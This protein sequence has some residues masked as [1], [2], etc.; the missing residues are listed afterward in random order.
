ML[1][2]N[3]SNGLGSF[4]DAL[5]GSAGLFAASGR[6][7]MASINF[8]TAHDGFTLAD[9]TAF[10]HKHNLDNQEEN[11]DGTG[12]NHS[13]N[14]GVEGITNNPNTLAQRARTSRNLMAT[15]LLA[16]GVPMITAGDEL[17]R[18][19]GGNNNVYCQDNEIAWV[20]WSLDEE[21]WTMLDAT[22]R[23]VRIRREFLAAQP[24]SF[25]TRGG[26]SFIHWFGAD[27]LPMTPR[28]WKSPDER[29]LTM[30]MGSPDGRV[31]GLVVFNTGVTDVDVVLPANPRFDAAEPVRNDVP[32][33]C[34]YSLRMST[35]APSR[36][37]DGEP[38]FRVPATVAPVAAGE[39]ARVD[40]NTVQI[41]RNDL[42]A[43]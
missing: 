35:A 7:R 14:H 8:V 22:R 17:G 16:L 41:Y 36:T 28:R 19:Q 29:V 2:G 12:E 13:W 26:Q 10:N 39:S 4:G 27:G 1:A 18:S 5:G 33:P 43:S 37:V 34:P 6:S 15:L 24:S 32:A 20:D 3:Y 11:R 25:P 30:L 23:L 38:T 42:T 31:D 40:A 9:L 21:A